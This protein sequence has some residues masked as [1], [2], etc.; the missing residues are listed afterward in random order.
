MIHCSRCSKKVR[1]IG[2]NF[3]EDTWRVD[4][5]LSNGKN[6]HWHKDCPRLEKLRDLKQGGVKAGCALGDGWEINLPG[7][8][9]GDDW[10]EKNK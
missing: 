2:P 7:I 6:V 8:V 1:V 5:I 10:K 9:C 3:L 4:R